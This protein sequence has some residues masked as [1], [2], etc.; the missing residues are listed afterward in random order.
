[1]F[2]SVMYGLV[3][4]DSF[5]LMYVFWE[6]T[7]ILSYMLV[8]YYGE[9]ASSRR[10]AIQALMIT[11]FGGLAMLVGINLLGY[12]TGIWRLS[13]VS[14]FANIENTPAISTAIV[15]IM[16]GAMTKSAQAPWHIW[17]PGAMAAPTPVSAYLH[18]AAM[19]KAGI[20]LVARLAPDMSAVTTWHLLVLSTGGF[21]MLL[22]GWMALKQRD[23]K[24]V[25]AY[26]TVSQLGFIIT[27][28]GVGSVSYTHLTL[29]TTPYV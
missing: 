14:Q 29:P 12:K 5:L 10:A 16:L 13:E 18:S 4:S 7:S 9:R 24:L 11:T 17:L 19:V 20:Y 2:A 6:L 23:L 3:I 21:T 22:G 27:V 26:G 28:I 1:M 15:L 8:S 25:L